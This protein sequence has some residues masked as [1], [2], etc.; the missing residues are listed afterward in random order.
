WIDEEGNSLII[1]K[2]NKVIIKQSKIESKKTDDLFIKSKPC[3]IYKYSYWALGFDIDNKT[4]ISFLGND[5]VL[6]S[7]LFEE[8]WKY[9]FRSILLG[10]DIIDYIAREYIEDDLKV[11]KSIYNKKKVCI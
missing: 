1:N 7:C 5:G 9:N 3:L 6:R 2:K 4:I 11:C 8:N 10:F